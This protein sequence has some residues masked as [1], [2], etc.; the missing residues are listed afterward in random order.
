MEFIVITHNSPNLDNT[1]ARKNK[2][3]NANT[4]EIYA[5]VLSAGFATEMVYC[6]CGPEFESS[7]RQCESMVGRV[8]I[9]RAFLRILPFSKFNSIII[10]QIPFFSFNLI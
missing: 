4:V 6:D 8:R 9:F 3:K 2:K 10:S 1:V 5:V 7:C